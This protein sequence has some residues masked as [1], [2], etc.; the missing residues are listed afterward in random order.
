MRKV[1][2]DLF[3]RTRRSQ[4]GSFCL[5]GR[6]CHTMRRVRISL[7]TRKG[8][9][10]CDM[11]HLTFDLCELC[12]KGFRS[13]SQIAKLGI[14]SSSTGGVASLRFGSGMLVL[15]QGA[16]AGCCLRVLLSEW[17]VRFGT[18]MLV[19]VQL[20]LACWCRCKVLLQA[21]AV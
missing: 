13:F 14:S 21:A 9:R 18:G 1:A 2:Q 6:Y 16:T 7:S 19:P 12:K 8:R 15:L 3:A 17:R 11:R 20:E 5:D 4:P 10:P